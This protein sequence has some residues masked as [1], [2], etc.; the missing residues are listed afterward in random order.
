MKR[1]VR[2]WSS[3]TNLHPTCGVA[4]WRWGYYIEEKRPRLLLEIVD[5]TAHLP[6]CLAASSG[7]KL[8]TRGLSITS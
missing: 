1:D 6:C 5:V 8:L 4:S 3:I 7:S 2:D